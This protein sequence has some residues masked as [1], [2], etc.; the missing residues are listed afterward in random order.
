MAKNIYPAACQAVLSQYAPMAHSLARASGLTLDDLRQ[1][2]ALAWHAGL[3]P[4]RAVPPAVGVRR[5][6]GGAWR[7]QDLAVAATAADGIEPTGEMPRPKARRGEVAAGVAADCGVGLRAAQKRLKRQLGAAE[8]G[9]G[10]L[11]TGGE[12]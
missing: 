5:L 12:G 9:Q 3:D 11:F 6:P 2:I 8:L 10:D 4:A 1:E 7:S